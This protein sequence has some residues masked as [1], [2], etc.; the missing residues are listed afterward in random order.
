MIEGQDVD[1][2]TDL[3]ALGTKDG[4]LLLVSCK[5]LAK[6]MQYDTGN[7]QTVRAARNTVKDA[8]E[9]LRLLETEIKQHPTAF[10]FDFTRYR[11]IVGVVCVPTVVFVPT[12]RAT[13]FVAPGL[14]AAVSANELSKW[15]TESHV[16]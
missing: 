10:N 16:L 6:T 7:Y 12:G 3:D 4:V 11:R 8:V 2:R 13:D 9:D 14:R 5:S 1:Q 15:M